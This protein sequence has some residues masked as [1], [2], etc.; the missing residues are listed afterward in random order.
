MQKTARVGCALYLDSVSHL[1]EIAF[2][3]RHTQTARPFRVFC[4]DL[5][6]AA[7]GK[8]EILRTLSTVRERLFDVCVF[9][10][11]LFFFFRAHRTKRSYQNFKN[12]KRSGRLSV[13]N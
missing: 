6:H 11:F 3:V 5:S 4:I 8:K 10:F 1:R 12:S 2:L 9:S 13:T 7:R